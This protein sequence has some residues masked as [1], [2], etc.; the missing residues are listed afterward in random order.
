MFVRTTLSVVLFFLLPM[1][2]WPQEVV[3][4]GLSTAPVT[5]HP[6]FATDAVS[7][8]IDR[9][10]YERLVDFDDRYR[11]VP[12]LADWEEIDPTHYRFTLRGAHRFHDGTPLT[13]ADVQATY[14]YV[15]DAAHASPHRQTVS[16]IAEIKTQNERQI[17]FILTRPDP[18]FPGRMTLGI[19]PARVLSA[20]AEALR[21]HPL[22]SG[23]LR[24]VAWPDETHLILERVADHARV[25]FLVVPNPVVRA[26]K[27][28]RGEIDLLQGD[29]L[30]EL[31]R[32]LQQRP[33]IRLQKRAGDTVAY[34]GF[35]MDDP[36][37]RD[38]RVR[39]A[40]AQAIDREAI[41]HQVLDGDA[42]PANGVLPPNHWAGAGDAP[43]RRYDPMAARAVLA[44]AGY[45][46]ARPLRLVYKTSSD[47]LRVRLASIFQQQLQDVG[48]E[49]DLRSNDWGTFYDDIKAGRFQMYGLS[50][51]G[52]KLPDIYRY[53]FHSGSVPPAGANRGRY[54]SGQVDALLDQADRADSV[55]RQQSIYHDI[56][57]IL[58]QELPIVPLWYEDVVAVMRGDVRGYTLSPD[59]NYDGL[60]TIRH[61]GR[62]NN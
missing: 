26:L 9:L 24:F 60:V 51:V 57:A 32:W 42:R 44:A 20:D 59:G 14:A 29:L 4:M 8:R 54:K 33:Q 58:L 28:A 16:M 46:P 12:A 25:E 61:G 43:G 35:N 55:D 7:E 11:P 15:L 13:A 62:T 47:P 41:I 49:V 10:L 18:L 36:A 27:I 52:L 39:T 6:L 37:L 23:P 1:N 3:R 38:V 53:A 50:W 34:L 30:P 31:Y 19:V 48:V 22:G 21:R 56:A 2:A 17:D 5:L 40:I 45:G